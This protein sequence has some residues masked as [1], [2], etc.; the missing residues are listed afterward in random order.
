M[1]ILLEEQKIEET[2]KRVPRDSFTV[3][4]FIDVFKVVYPEDWMRLKGRFGQFGE[5]RR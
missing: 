2:I 4:D 3:L 1:K 5:K